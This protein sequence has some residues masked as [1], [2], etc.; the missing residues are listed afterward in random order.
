MS[1]LSRQVIFALSCL[2]TGFN[3]HAILSVNKSYGLPQ[4]TYKCHLARGMKAA[5]PASKAPFQLSQPSGWCS[6][7]LS[8]W[9]WSLSRLGLSLL[10]H[11]TA[12][13]DI[14]WSDHQ[15]TTVPKTICMVNREDIQ[16]AAYKLDWIITNNLRSTQ[17]RES[18]ERRPW[19]KGQVGRGR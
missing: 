9:L 8:C 12:L 4:G 14:A 2:K 15:H 5:A 3:A 16:R 18:W 17:K 11:V 10:I 19:A 6:L 13:A 7:L 1:I